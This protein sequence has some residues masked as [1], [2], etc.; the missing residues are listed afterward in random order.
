[1]YLVI[2]P[3]GISLIDTVRMGC[4][5]DLALVGRLLREARKGVSYGHGN[6]DRHGQS[7]LSPG[8]QGRQSRAAAA[9]A[10]HQRDAR[11]AARDAHRRKATGR[12]AGEAPRSTRFAFLAGGIIRL[13]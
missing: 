2:L 13:L 6:R 11:S 9:L 3:F 1:P 10:S 7:G 12:T 5:A 8:V 4:S